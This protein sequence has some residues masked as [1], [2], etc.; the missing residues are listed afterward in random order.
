MIE[1]GFEGK[2]QQESWNC[3]IKTDH[4]LPR[5]RSVQAV[6]HD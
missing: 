6:V 5:H 3:G 2:K 1:S 4:D